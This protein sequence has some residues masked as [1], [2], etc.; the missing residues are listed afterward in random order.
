M[1]ETD[2]KE[3][4]STSSASNMEIKLKSDLLL[5]K[6]KFDDSSTLGGQSNLKIIDQTLLLALWY[7]IRRSFFVY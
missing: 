6:P 2:S 1:S 4:E 5:E 7:V 3:S